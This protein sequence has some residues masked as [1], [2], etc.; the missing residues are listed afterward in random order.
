MKPVLTCEERLLPQPGA[1]WGE[2]S[3]PPAPL[4]P[5]ELLLLL[6][7]DG[8]GCVVTRV[9]KEWDAPRATLVLRDGAVLHWLLSVDPCE[10]HPAFVVIQPALAQQVRGSA[11]LRLAYAQG[12]WA[13]G[14]SGILQAALPYLFA[15]GA[16]GSASVRRGDKTLICI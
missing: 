3:W 14:L 4:E 5:A 2:H 13:T 9:A 10:I 7:G 15:L 16:A 1:A 6:G 11:P 12:S 8:D